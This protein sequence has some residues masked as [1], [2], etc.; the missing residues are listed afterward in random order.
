MKTVGSLIIIITNTIII[1]SMY[2]GYNS[3][4]WVKYL[5]LLY[6]VIVEIK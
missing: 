3:E 6:Q 4:L 2:C 5:C 1:A